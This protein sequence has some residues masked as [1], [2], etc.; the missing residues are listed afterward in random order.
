[1]KGIIFNIY[2]QLVTRD[3][4]EDAWDRLLDES[5]LEGAHTSLG[6]YPDSDLM[7]LVEAA[8]KAWDL[9]ADEG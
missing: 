3:R 2:E 1:M 9:P 6:S 8:S 7:K 5:G 4:G